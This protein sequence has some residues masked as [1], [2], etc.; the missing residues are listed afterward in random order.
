MAE[1][2]FQLR[3]DLL[4]A[5]PQHQ[6]P[7]GVHDQGAA[8]R[9]QSAELQD[10]AGSTDTARATQNDPFSE[11]KSKLGRAANVGE[12]CARGL[13]GA[14]NTLERDPDPAARALGAKL[15]ELA[16]ATKGTADGIRAAHTYLSPGLDKATA[17]V[18]IANMIESI[19]SAN[20]ALHR[21][22]TASPADR[23]DASM[24]LASE[25]GDAFATAGAFAEGLPGSLGTYLGGLF[26]TPARVINEFNKIVEKR[27]QRLDKG[28]GSGYGERCI[29]PIDGRILAEGPDAREACLPPAVLVGGR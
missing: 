8:A 10:H 1:P 15:K 26:A 22:N 11:V 24:A 13:A 25:L 12:Q 29:D 21:F 3:E 20:L 28:A 23:L 9:A 18:Q 5:P 4:H 7:T 19:H 14:G 6:A 16:S 2:S 17:V 27:V